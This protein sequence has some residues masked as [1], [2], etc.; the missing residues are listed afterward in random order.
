LLEKGRILGSM[1]LAAVAAIG[2]ALGTV[3][4]VLSFDRGGAA[5][6]IATVISLAVGAAFGT[7]VFVVAAGKRNS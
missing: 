5:Y 1:A 6:P 7:A 3:F 2:L 4:A